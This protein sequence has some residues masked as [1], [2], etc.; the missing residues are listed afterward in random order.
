[1]ECMESRL[2]GELYRR[3]LKIRE[4]VSLTSINRGAIGIDFPKSKLTSVYTALI[5]ER[6]YPFR[7]INK[8]FREKLDFIIHDPQ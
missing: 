3:A 2:R 7:H 5:E 6:Q 1:M 8:E 4:S